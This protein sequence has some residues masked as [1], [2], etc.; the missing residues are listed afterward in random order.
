MGNKAL[1]TTWQRKRPIGVVYP[2]E[3]CFH[4][5]SF[6]KDEFGPGAQSGDGKP[7]EHAQIY[8][9]LIRAE[10]NN[11]NDLGQAFYND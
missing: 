3:Q 8:A 6:F 7:I 5:V 11:D 2:G 9:T 4:C 1:P 10:P